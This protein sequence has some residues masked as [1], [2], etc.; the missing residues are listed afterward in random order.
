MKKNIYIF[1]TIFL[2]L[3]LNF[4]LHAWIES[5]YIKHSI[6]NVLMNTNFL[7]HF[8]CIFPAWLNYGSLLVTLIGG[9]FLGQFWWRVIYIEKR[10]WLKFRRK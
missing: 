2:L 5:F 1:L 7:G 3:E 6:G 4:L 8:Y 9:Y 10:H